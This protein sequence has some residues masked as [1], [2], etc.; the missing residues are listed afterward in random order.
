MAGPSPRCSAPD[1]T[2]GGADGQPGH[3]RRGPRRRRGAALVAGREAA[4]GELEGILPPQI[5]DETLGD[6]AYHIDELLFDR[7]RQEAARVA[8]AAAD[9][10]CEAARRAPSPTPAVKEAAEVMSHLRREIS[11]AGAPPGA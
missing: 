10:L 1:R 5:G 4:A 3:V 2:A 7:H 9:W 6:I 11:E 8:L